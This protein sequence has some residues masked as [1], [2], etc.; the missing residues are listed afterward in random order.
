MTDLYPWLDPPP[1]PPLPPLLILPR[2]LF[3]DLWPDRPPEAYGQ[4]LRDCLPF[5]PPRT[6]WAPDGGWWL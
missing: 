4:Y 2:A 1:A 3:F 5:S 6:P